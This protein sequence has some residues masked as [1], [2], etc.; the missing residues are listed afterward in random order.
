MTEG[1]DFYREALRLKQ[2]LNATHTADRGYAKDVVDEWIVIG[3]IQRQAGSLQEAGQ[4]YDQAQDIL[5]PLLEAE[6][7]DSELQGEL[8]RVLERKACVLGDLGQLKDALGLLGQAVALAES[9]LRTAEDGKKPREYLSEALWNFAR[10]LRESG[11]EK[12]ANRLDAERIA[13]WKKRPVTELV[14]L[15]SSQATRADLIGYGATPVLPAGRE[16]PRTRPG[17]GR[18]QPLSRPKWRIQGFRQAQGQPGS[19]AAA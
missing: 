4:S 7:N 18:S 2:Q 14:D 10:L 16:S 9:S 19:R 8:A 15:A 11:Q 1:L 13:L 5:R 12:D 3:N 17:S 6:A